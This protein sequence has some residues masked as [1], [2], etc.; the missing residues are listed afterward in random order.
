MAE[1]EDGEAVYAPKDM[2]PLIPEFLKEEEELKGASRG[3]A[4]HKLLELLDFSA[5]VSY[6][7][8]RIM[9]LYVLS[10]HLTGIR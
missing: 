7:H 9:P 3:S 8:L 4:Y 10:L 6:T 1:E 2:V 5:A